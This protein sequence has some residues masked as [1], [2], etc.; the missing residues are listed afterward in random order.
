MAKSFNCC[1]LSSG[2]SIF[3][4]SILSDSDEKFVNIENHGR[5]ALGGLTVGHLREF[6]CPKLDVS[7]MREL[8]LWKVDIDEEEI[9]DGFTEN[10]IKTKLNGIRMK[11]QKLFSEYFEAELDNKVGF[12]VS[13][14]HIIIVIPATT[15]GKCLQCFTSRTKNLQYKRFTTTNIILMSFFFNC[16]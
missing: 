2:T 10:D 14:I 13:N 9:E 12:S 6:M 15:T 11:P 7:V 4:F 8:K 5:I 3:P 1:V 16:S